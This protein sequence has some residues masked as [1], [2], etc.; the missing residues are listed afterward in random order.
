MKEILKLGFTLFVFCVI[1]A[2]ALGVT[3][4]MTKDQ[5]AENTIV[6]N[7]EARQEVFSEAD[8]FKLIATIEDITETPDGQAY[9]AHAQAQVYLEAHPDVAEIYEAYSGDTRVG[10]VIKTLPNGYG[11]ALEVIVGFDLEGTLTG[12]RVGNHQET[13]GLG[14]NA[15]TESFYSQYDGLTLTEPVLVTKTEVKANEI[16]AISGA[17]ITSDAVTNGVNYGTSVLETFK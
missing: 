14:A 7:R 8:S 17:T 15:K 5:I 16:L 2:F 9:T 4:E 1:A 6:A 11:G 3:N 12:V 10:F 13:P